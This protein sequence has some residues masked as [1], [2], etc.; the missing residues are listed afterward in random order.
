MK[1]RNRQG[2]LQYHLIQEAEMPS[3]TSDSIWTVDIYI[4]TYF[5]INLA[6]ICFILRFK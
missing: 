1:H 4:S 5:Q 2:D 6:I 3:N